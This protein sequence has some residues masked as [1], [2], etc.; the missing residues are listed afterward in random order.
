MYLDGP[1]AVDVF[2][3]RDE[4]AATGLAEKIASAL[5][6]PAPRAHN[7]RETTLRLDGAAV[8]LMACWVF[9]TLISMTFSGGV[10]GPAASVSDWL[11]IVTSVAPYVL[12]L[13]VSARWLVRRSLA[14]LERSEPNTRG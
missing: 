11:S 5:A 7:R 9:A 14:P 10:R 6:L 8:A 1:R 2:D 3:T 13:T 12:L 4:A